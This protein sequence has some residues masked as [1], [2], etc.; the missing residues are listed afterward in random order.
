MRRLLWA[1]VVV[2]AFPA[3]AG[4]NV[5]VVYRPD[6]P[7]Y[8]RAKLATQVVHGAALCAVVT[9]VAWAANSHGRNRTAAFAVLGTFCLVMLIFWNGSRTVIA[10]PDDPPTEEEVHPG[11]GAVSGEEVTLFAAIVAI[12]LAGFGVKV[13]QRDA[14]AQAREFRQRVAAHT[15]APPAPPNGPP[16][17]AT[18]R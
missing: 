2:L 4:A 11:P 8:A 6:H 10:A 9:G 1:G 14:A 17:P 7:G 15:P 16:G 13:A 5:A 18:P 12:A 3:V